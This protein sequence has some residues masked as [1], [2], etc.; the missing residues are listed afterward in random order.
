[1]TNI[2][3]YNT[4]EEAQRTLVENWGDQGKEVI[5]LAFKAKKFV[6]DR[7]EDAEMWANTR[8]EVMNCRAIAFGVI[9]FAQ[10]IEIA[11]YEEIKEYWDNYA[12]EKF[13]EIA[14]EKGKGPKVEV[15]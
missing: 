12:W 3:L 15:I 11:T 9:M 2:E 7:L 14:K 13:E 4:I 10:R 5:A 8:L 6:D 1:M